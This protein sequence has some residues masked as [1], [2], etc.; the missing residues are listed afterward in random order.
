MEIKRNKDFGRCVFAKRDIEIGQTVLVAEHFASAITSEK[1]AY[2]LTCE[3]TEMNF[4]PCKNCSYVC[5]CD[6]DCANY[7]NLHKMECQTCYHQIE[8]VNLKFIVQTILVAIDIFPDI[9]S[10]IAFVEETISDKGCDKIPKTSCDPPSKYGIFLKLTP[11]YKD[12]HLFLAYQAFTYINLIPKVKYLFD[13]EPKQ[14]FLL[15]L[16]LHHTTVIPKNA[17]YDIAQ[18]SDQYTVKYIFDVL[19]IV[20]NL[21]L[22]F[23][24]KKSNQWIIF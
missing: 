13:T 23:N 18:F 20:S 19:S 15:H 2:C 11:S 16:V 7:D 6:E 17:F 10:L 5:F 9:E 22:F 1:Q 4:I 21:L 14:R 8:D 12:E 3:K 24:K